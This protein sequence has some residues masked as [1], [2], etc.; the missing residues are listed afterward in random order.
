[1]YSENILSEYA[2]LL[3]EGGML[4]TITDVK[5]LFD[6]NVRLLDSHPQFKRVPNEQL[7]LQCE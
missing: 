4:Y 6:W 3:K 1:M 5:D 7:V 2:Y